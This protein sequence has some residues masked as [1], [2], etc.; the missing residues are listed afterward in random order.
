MNHMNHLIDID[1]LP[2]I[3]STIDLGTALIDWNSEVGL[4]FGDALYDFYQYIDEVFGWNASDD[5]N[6]ADLFRQ[7]FF[8]LLDA[9]IFRKGFSD[10]MQFTITMPKQFLAVSFNV[11]IYPDN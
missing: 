5:D 9:E 11:C 8:K 7:E 6:R 2:N 1:L 3:G 10:N 4:E